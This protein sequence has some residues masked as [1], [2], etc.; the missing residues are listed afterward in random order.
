MPMRNFE[1]GYGRTLQIA[2]FEKGHGNR[3]LRWVSKIS[4]GVVGI[5]GDGGYRVMRNHSILL[6]LWLKRISLMIKL[7][8]FSDTGISI[9]S[10]R[11]PGIYPIGRRWDC[12]QKTP[13]VSV[14]ITVRREILSRKSGRGAREN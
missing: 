6:D 3:K 12:Q 11:N 14:G 8:T 1:N 5:A 4:I 13:L 2:S 10:Y 7:D 9:V